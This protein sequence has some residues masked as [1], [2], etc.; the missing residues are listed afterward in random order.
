MERTDEL[1]WDFQRQ[2]KGAP[3][4]TDISEPHPAKAPPTP[5]AREMDKMLADAQASVERVRAINRN[6]ALRSPKR[7]PCSST[8]EDN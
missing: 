7:K 2:Q 5:L 6:S 3:W 4:R 1:Q 8:I